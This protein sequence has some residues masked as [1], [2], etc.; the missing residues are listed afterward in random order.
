MSANRKYFEAVPEERLPLTDEEGEV[1]ELTE[2]DF[3]HFRPTTELM[4]EF[5]KAFE[6]MRGTRGA[7][8][9]PLKE[10]I[11][12]RLDADVVAHF[13]STG[14]GWQ[15]R[16]NDILKQHMAGSAAEGHKK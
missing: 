1:R 10:R 15:A 16:M 5:I 4:P 8:K 2:G 3:K 11:G 7:Q 14:T 13:R 9:A 12:L 6:R